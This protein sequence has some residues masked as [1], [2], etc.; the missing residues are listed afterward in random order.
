MELRG[1]GQSLKNNTTA[2]SLLHQ[3]LQLAQCNQ[4]GTVLLVVAKPILIHQTG[5]WRNMVLFCPCT[6]QNTKP[7]T[8]HLMQRLYKTKCKNLAETIKSRLSLRDPWNRCTSLHYSW[9]CCN[10]LAVFTLVLSLN[11]P[12][13]KAFITLLVNLWGWWSLIHPEAYLWAPEEQLDS[14]VHW[15]FITAGAND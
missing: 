13:N 8:R 5:R 14:H 12:N 2:L 1:P 10:S 6:V 9:T 7:P 4:T 11:D 15:E 3:T